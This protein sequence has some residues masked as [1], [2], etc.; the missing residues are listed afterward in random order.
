M[1]KVLSLLAAFG[2]VASA[3]AASLV[4]S[5]NAIAFNG[6]T[7][8]SDTSLTAYLVYLG[9]GGSLADSY[10]T[11]TIASSLTT[12]S[13]ASGTTS[14]GIATSTYNM[15]VDGDD[16]TVLNGD[17]YGV[18]LSYADS[19]SGKTYYNLASTT[20]TV[21]GIADERSSLSNYTLTAASQNYT[22]ADDSSTIRAGGGWTAVPEPSTAAL[23]LAGLALLLKRRKA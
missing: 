20:Y 10:D 8:K 5:V 3:S 4:W 2:L 22:T 13:T 14:R 23:A 1:K 17:V 6:A 12:V 21:S 18:L 15:T 11:A 16:W 9:N 19:A 7:L